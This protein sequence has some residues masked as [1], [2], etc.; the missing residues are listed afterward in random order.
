MIDVIHKKETKL[1][2]TEWDARSNDDQSKVEN[3][4]NQ[5]SMDYKL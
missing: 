2:K 4:V 5:V 1:R 3:N